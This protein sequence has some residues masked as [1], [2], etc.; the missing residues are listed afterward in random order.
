MTVKLFATAVAA[1]ATVGA[2]A[3]G[4]A[5]LAPSGAPALQVQP[6]ALGAPLPIDAPPADVPTDGELSSLLTNLTNPGVNYHSKAGLVENGISS[7]DGH[8]ADH[9]LRDAFEAGKFPLAFDVSNIQSVG[10]NAAAADVNITGPKLAAPL[11][12]HLAFVDQGGWKI[13]HDSAL[14]L[15][16]AISAS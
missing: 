10:P 2:A 14:A 13:Q 11:T 9:Q 6:V 3:A 12:Q 5:S 16:Q 4:M 7:G 1:V 8:A 15:I